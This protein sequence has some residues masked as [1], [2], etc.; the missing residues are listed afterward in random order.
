MYGYAS[1]LLGPIEFQ[2]EWTAHHL[3]EKPYLVAFF[4]EWPINQTVGAS[5]FVALVAV[6]SAQFRF[7]VHF[8][9]ATDI[10][11]VLLSTQYFETAI[12]RVIILNTWEHGIY[13]NDTLFF[14]WLLYVRHLIVKTWNVFYRFFVLLAPL[15]FWVP[16]KQ[17]L[18][19]AFATYN[20]SVCHWTLD[21]LR[22][23][24][25]I[26][27]L[28]SQTIHRLRRPPARSSIVDRHSQPMT[29][30]WWLLMRTKWTTKIDSY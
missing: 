17:L 27:L 10:A 7:T 18:P 15:P 22:C 6:P 23:Q 13:V 29:L 11:Y 9:N 21:P 19:E 3:L 30:K 25:K 8:D 20:Q 14:M 24:S 26:C 2:T 12:V 5:D 16:Y 1:Q 4:Q 28:A